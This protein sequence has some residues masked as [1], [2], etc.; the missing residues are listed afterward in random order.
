[1][2]PLDPFSWNA[3]NAAGPIDRDR[4]GS[5]SDNQ[6]ELITLRGQVDRLTLACQAMWELIR[7]S[8]SFSESE[9]QEKITEVDL[10]D[11]AADGRLGST[12]LKCPSCGRNSNSRRDSCIWCGG[13]IEREH[14]F[15]G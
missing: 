1:M 10:R 13:P 2:N 11:G 9:L 5:S 6:A 12:V 4:T 7:E 8:G 3:G 14:I 15:E